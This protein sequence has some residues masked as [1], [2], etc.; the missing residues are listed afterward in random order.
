MIRKI[1]GGFILFSVFG[2]IFVMVAIESD[3]KTA[4][5]VFGCA[6]TLFILIILAI[7]LMT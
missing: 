3:F 1:I 7:K 2:G 4:A 6:F 5:F